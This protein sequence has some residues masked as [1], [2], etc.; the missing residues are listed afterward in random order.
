MSIENGRVYVNGELKEKNILI[1]NGK[2]KKITSEKTNAD[3]KVNAKGMVVLPG[4]IDPHVHFRD[5]GLTHKEDFRTGSFAAAAGGTTC[6]LDLP[7]TKP[8]TLTNELLGGKRDIAS[9][10]SVVNY[11]FHFGSSLNNIEEVK[12]VQ[13][14]PSVKIFMDAST[15]NMLIEDGGIIKSIMEVSGINTI[16]AEW[17]NVRR[18]IEFAKTLGKKFYLCHISEKSELD[19]IR[20]NGKENVFVEVTPH[21]LFLTEREQNKFVIMKP[22]LKKESDRKVLW[23]ALRDGTIDTMGTDH[24]PHTIEEK[25]SSEVFGV[26]GVETR[27]PLMLDALNKGKITLKRLVETMCE[28]PAKIFKIKNKGFIKEGGDGDLTIIDMKLRKRVRNDELFTKCGWSPFDGFELQGW[29]VI[30]IVNGNVVFENGEVH[31]KI[32]GEEAEYG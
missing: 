8:P 15:G 13:G 12:N 6:V 3:E 31:D 4:V 16:H 22:S 19:Y 29:P 17:E 9:R 7:N 25:E 11:G 30:T 24:A 5:P 2:I 18:A 1:E 26:P 21:H 10:K 20:E 23:E 32:R 14:V 28:N 27:V